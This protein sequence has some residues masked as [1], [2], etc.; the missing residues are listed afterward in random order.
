M[1]EKK[2][3]K[4]AYKRFTVSIPPEMFD[5][6]EAF[7][8][9]NSRSEIIRK[10]VYDYMNKDI[11]KDIDTKGDVVGCIAMI[12]SHGHFDVSGASSKEDGK[13]PDHDHPHDHE[14]GHHEHAHEGEETHHHHDYEY[15]NKPIY[16]NIEQRDLLLSNDI[17]HHFADI[18][19]SNMHIHLEFDKCLEI[20]AISGPYKQ[21]EHLRDSLNNLKSVLSLE[22]FIV[23]KL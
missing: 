22:L 12:M 18:I 14:H 1:G 3:D 16:A 5:S 2:E 17:Q 4:E 11:D 7:R 21:V 20:I 9:K 23:N 19:V 13:E 8:K 6:L 10:A 15:T